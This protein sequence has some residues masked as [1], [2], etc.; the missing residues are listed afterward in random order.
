MNIL[1]ALL[2]FVVGWLSGLWLL[3]YS[4]TSYLLA[5]GGQMLFLILALACAAAAARC[6]QYQPRRAGEGRLLRQQAHDRSRPV[7]ILATLLSGVLLNLWLRLGT[8]AA[9]LAGNGGR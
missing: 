3:S 4:P 6:F 8:A 1:V 7:L 9:I 5:N 2:A